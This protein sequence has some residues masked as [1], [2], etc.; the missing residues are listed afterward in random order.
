[1]EKPSEGILWPE[2]ESEVIAAYRGSVLTNW[3]AHI[4]RLPNPILLKT[5]FPDIQTIKRGEKHCR[6]YPPFQLNGTAEAGA[7]FQGVHIPEGDNTVSSYQPVPSSAVKG[8]VVEPRSD[9]GELY[10]Q[11]IRLDIE[12]DFPEDV[13][14]KEIVDQITQ[15]THQ[16]WLRSAQAPFRG[17]FQLGGSIN[18]NYRLLSELKYRGAGDVEST[19]YGARQT[20]QLMGIERPLTSSLWLLCLHNVQSRIPADNGLLAF[21]DAL[22]HYM[23]REDERCILDLAICFEILANKRQMIAGEKAESKNKNLLKKTDLVDGRIANIIAKLI[24]DRDHVSHGRPP[25]ILGSSDEISIETYLDAMR[26]VV[27]KY[28][29]LVQPGEWPKLAAMR[30]E[31]TRRR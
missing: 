20:Q 3:E 7:I 28:L 17:P 25:Y 6:V 19:W 9:E 13:V 16:W 29:S 23:A 1:M 12:A 10:C 11:G 18:K 30:L 15:Y 22:G 27:N 21:A 2:M 8:V 14:L 5:A 24:I 26:V 4:Y 31:S